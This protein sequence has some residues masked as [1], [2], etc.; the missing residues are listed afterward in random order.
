[1]TCPGGQIGPR[2]GDEQLIID[3]LGKFSGC[4]GWEMTRAPIFE[5]E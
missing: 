2:T 5:P 1:M 3:F 4:S